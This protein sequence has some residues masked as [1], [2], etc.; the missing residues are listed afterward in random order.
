MGRGEDRF[1]T[2]SA[3]ALLLL[4]HEER[5]DPACRVPRDPGIG[6]WGREWRE[7]KWGLRIWETV[8][9]AQSA[10]E[11]QAATLGQLGGSPSPLW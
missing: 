5:P 6:Q 11:F 2:K 3:A 7:G 9:E 10:V 8:V 4:L 1:F